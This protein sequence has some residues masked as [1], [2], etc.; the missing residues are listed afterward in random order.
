MID[1]TDKQ[2]Q[3]LAE[4]FC[5][6]SVATIAGGSITALVDKSILPLFALKQFGIFFIVGLIFLVAS[7]Y[8]RK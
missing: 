6:L 1:L 8:I 7:L 4:F 2:K 3:V 5:Q